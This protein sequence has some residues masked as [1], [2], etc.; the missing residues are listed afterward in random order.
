MSTGLQGLP[1]TLGR[2][3]LVAALGQGGMGRVVRAHDP[4]LKRD[5]ALKLFEPAQV[6]VDNLAEARFMFHREARATAALRHPGVLEVYDYSGPDAEIAYMACELLPGPTL[7][8]VF[9]T[10][11]AMPPETVAA[12]GHELASALEHAHARAIIHRD[13]KP[14]NIFWLEDGRVVLADFGIAKALDGSKR[15]GNTLQF[16]PTSVYGSPAYM[17]PEQLSGGVIG[18]ATD[19]HALGAIL[20]E[21]LTGEQAFD[22][23]DVD[24]IF[25]ALLADRRPTLAGRVDAPATFVAL[26]ESLLSKSADDRP[27]SAAAVARRLRQILDTLDVTDPRLAL[28]NYGD[29]TAALLGDRLE[30]EARFDLDDD[31]ARP[32]AL[33]PL[34]EQAGSVWAEHGPLLL[35]TAILAVGVGVMAYLFVDLRDAL[36]GLNASIDTTAP[37]ARKAATGG[38]SWTDVPVMITFVG[39][40]A[41]FVDGRLSGAAD[42]ALRLTLSPGPH[43][44]LLRLGAQELRQEVVVLP[45]TEPLFDFTRPPETPENSA[46]R[47]IPVPSGP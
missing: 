40:G 30:P 12:L 23:A 41:L 6:D 2:Y 35:G 18:P 29:D 3:E 39:R 5:V 44:L 22:G 26:V 11:G 46:I 10:A 31:T 21:A 27:T 38:D 9:E 25:Q 19:L 13:L 47:E 36:S 4:V 37:E 16:G 15:L 14:E 7:R 1:K 33:E 42:D 17:A 8:Q 28:R 32:N 24:A 20:F 34:T 43:D 45:G